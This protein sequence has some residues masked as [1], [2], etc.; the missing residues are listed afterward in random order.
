M[1]NM[2]RLYRPITKKTCGFTLIEVLLAMAVFAIAGV[3]LLNNASTT[4]NNLSHIE[5]QVFASWVASNQLVNQSLE[6]S[7]PP[8]NNQDGKT[9]MA[10]HEWF[11]QT[12]VVKTTDN[13]MRAIIVEVRTDEEQELIDASLMTYV[14]KASK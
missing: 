5:K 7:W 6:T 14:S 12:Q 4:F 1:N 2:P 3:A 13:N 9:E 10:G 8:K 11:W